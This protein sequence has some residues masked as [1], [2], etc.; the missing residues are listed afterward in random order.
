MSWTVLMILHQQ[1]RLFKRWRQRSCVPDLAAGLADGLLGLL[2]RGLHGL[3]LHSL[4]EPL[5]AEIDEPPQVGE[6]RQGHAD[7]A[8]RV[9]FARTH[10]SLAIRCVPCRRR[11]YRRMRRSR[12]RTPPQARAVW[13]AMPGRWTARPA[14]RATG[15]Y[16]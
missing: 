16:R 6:V 15:Q 1:A 13:A 8:A 10:S 2:L 5:Q 12:R 4:L 14:L 7:G 3:C 9:E 11:R